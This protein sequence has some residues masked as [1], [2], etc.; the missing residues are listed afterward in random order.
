[1]GWFE[2]GGAR[3]PIDCRD[4]EQA[5]FTGDALQRVGPAIL[6]L[7][8][9]AGNEIPEYA[10]DQDLPWPCGCHGPGR[11]M[12]RDPGELGTEHLGLAD[13]QSGADLDPELAHA[14]ADGGST[15]NPLGR[16]G[17]RG[18]EPIAGRVKLPPAEALQKASY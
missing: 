5:P 14:V 18:E 13:V 12:D 10:G 1:L 17:E 2:L 4:R 9:S 16:F 8:A 3:L 11:D 7:E 15:A 6:E